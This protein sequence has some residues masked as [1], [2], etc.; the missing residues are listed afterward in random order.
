MA[1]ALPLDGYVRVSR[2]GGREGEGFISPQVQEKAILDWAKRNGREVL[3]RP[4]EL[5]VSGGTM[6]RPIFNE[7]MARVRAGESGGIVVYKSDRFARS[8]IGA[9]TTLAE[10]GEHGAAFSSVTEPN[11]DYSTP[12]G[13]A[14]LH[15]LFVF[16]EFLR[17]TLKESWATSQRE[18]VMRGVHISPAGFLGYNKGPDGRL[19]PDV[20]AQI[21]VEVFERRGEAREGWGQI[22]KWLNEVAPRD[23]GQWTG[24]AVQRLCA[25]R[26]YRGEASRYVHQNVDGRD[27]IVNADAHPALVTEE[28][29][30]SAQ[31]EPL[32][33]GRNITPGQLLSGLVRC[34]G[35]RYRMSKG[36]GPGGEV[37]YRCRNNHASGQ[38]PEPASILVDALD[39]HVEAAILAEL[40]TLAQ[41]V[42]D[43]DERER[44]MEKLATAQAALEDFR[45]D[46]AAR[47]KLGAEWHE[48]LDPYLAEV[49]SAQIELDQLDGL[50]GIGGSEGMARDHYLALSVDDRREVLGGFLD[51]VIVRRSRGRGRNVDP[52]S[53]RSRILW[54]GE[55]PADLPR[56]PLTNTI[57]SFDFGEDDAETRP[58]AA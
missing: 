55:A 34:A 15:M 3:M 20:E 5:N 41:V 31:M 16:A 30:R 56:R 2:V 40:D 22:A 23:K 50:A 14:F 53:E 13:Q 26:V 19:I 9:V 57:K 38:C 51:A 21:A 54:R 47:K 11:L 17:S 27:P 8:L 10:L 24:A 6:D 58:V 32:A 37:L 43:S 7:C 45:K 48:W 18:A 33:T 35:C 28:L 52:T 1:K 25:N 29:W 36:K 39:R 12:A 4:H 42:P 49:R 44:V 46:T